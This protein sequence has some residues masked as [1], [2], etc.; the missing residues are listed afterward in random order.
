M[1]ETN[2]LPVD[3]IESFMMDVFQG[4][5]VPEDEAH[6]CADVLIASDLR[7]QTVF[8]VAVDP[9][10]HGRVYAGAT[11]GLYLS[12]DRGITWSQLGLQDITVTALAW[13]EAQPDSLYAGTKHR[14][15][16]RSSDGG[17]TWQA[18]G[19]TGTTIHALLISPDGRWLYTG[20][21]SGVWRADLS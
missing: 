5:D 2:Y 18:V 15:I 4:L 20:T 19:L 14:G 10:Q 13:Q 8:I 1:T 17:H 3:V 6:I 11:N 9:A 16:W 21:E 12:E 7:G